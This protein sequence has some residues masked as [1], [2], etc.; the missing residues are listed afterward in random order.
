MGYWR[1]ISILKTAHKIHQIESGHLYIDEGE[2]PKST[3]DMIKQR[4]KQR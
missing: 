3:K 1:F 4:V 2:L